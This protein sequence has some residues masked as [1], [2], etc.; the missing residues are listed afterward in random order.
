MTFFV[1]GHVGLTTLHNGGFFSL[2]QD[3]ASR[4]VIASSAEPYNEQ[5]V[6][7]ILRAKAGPVIRAPDD[8]DEFVDWLER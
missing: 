6:R 2:L 7:R 8:P 1:T 3:T 4:R 5:A